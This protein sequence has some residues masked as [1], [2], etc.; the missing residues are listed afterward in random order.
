MER[1]SK[2]EEVNWSQVAAE[3]FEKKLR[4][5]AQKNQRTA[6]HFELD[7]AIAER[8]FGWKVVQMDYT[9]RTGKVSGVIPG[10]KDSD[11]KIRTLDE[12]PRFSSDMNSANDAIKV[13]GNK[14]Q[15]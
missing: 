4:E 3:A 12:L 14:Q 11:G 8:L 6:E 5:L 13:A 15:I 9:E 1:A 2:T 10:F 7:A